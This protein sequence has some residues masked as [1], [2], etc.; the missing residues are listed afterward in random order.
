MLGARKNFKKNP[1]KIVEKF[2]SKKKIVKKFLGLEKNS[3]K[4]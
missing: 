2:G 1:E 4:I 3:I